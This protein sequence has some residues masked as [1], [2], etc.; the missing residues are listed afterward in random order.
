MAVYG[1]VSI[2]PQMKG[3]FGVEILVATPGRL[4]DLI[5][6][7]AL[8]ISQISHLVV[9]EADKMF[10]LGFEEEMNKLLGM[11]PAMKQTIMF[12]ATL[13]EKVEEIKNV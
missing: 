3:M 2:N 13:N 5:E 9:D 6:H 11:M 7:N 4:L 10:Q 1:G 12:S 8:S